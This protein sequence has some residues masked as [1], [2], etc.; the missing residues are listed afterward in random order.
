MNKKKVKPRVYHGGFTIIELIIAIVIIGVLAGIVIVNI[1]ANINKSKSAAI[2]E[3]MSSILSKSAVHYLGVGDGSY[4]N[5]DATNEKDA[6][7]TAQG[8]LGDAPDIVVKTGGAEFCVC[9][10]LLPYS[11]SGSNN[12]YYCVDSSG[13]RREYTGKA[14]DQCL[15]ICPSST[16]QCASS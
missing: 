8:L 10:S 3:N 11:T 7:K 9:A 6:I 12:S 1:F 16:A 14:K 15:I 2:K 4:V 13:I 5:F